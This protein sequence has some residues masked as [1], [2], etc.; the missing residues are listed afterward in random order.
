MLKKLAFDSNQF[1]VPSSLV[2]STWSTAL[3]HLAKNLPVVEDLMIGGVGVLDA[4][5]LLIIAQSCGSTLKNLV[6]NEVFADVGAKA[7][8]EAAKYL[9]NIEKLKIGEPISSTSLLNQAH[10]IDPMRP[11]IGVTLAR[12]CPRLIFFDCG[13]A[14]MNETINEI[15]RAVKSEFQ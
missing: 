9:S 13:N 10:A 5:S 8:I 14:E 15:L 11:V 12:R 6:F 2:H 4:H 7:I 3:E 1:D